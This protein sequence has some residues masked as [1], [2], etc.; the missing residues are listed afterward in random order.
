MLYLLFVLTLLGGGAAGFFIAWFV[1]NKEIDIKDQELAIEKRA[2]EERE[3]GGEQLE[4]RFK[5]VASDVMRVYSKDF[6]EEFERARKYHNAD[7]K[8]EK[9]GIARIVEGLS[10]S[11][12]TVDKKMDE[13]EKQRAEQ[14]GAL[15]ASI[16]NVLDTGAK[17]QEA[18]LSLKTVL[19]SASAVR[20]RWGE[21]VLSNF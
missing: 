5:A 18:A 12:E 11:M 21:A 9:E 2:L 20:G 19:S 10:K 4:V 1:K 6:L 7:L 3:K 13:F 17:M 16:K 14:A 8:T 15:G